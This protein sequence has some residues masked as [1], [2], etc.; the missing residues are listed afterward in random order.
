MQGLKFF[1]PVGPIT[2]LG[3]MCALR[4][5]SGSHSLQEDGLV[6]E[7]ELHIW[8]IPVRTT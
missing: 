5:L 8:V 6:R 7:K 4:D 3:E 2:K 1:C